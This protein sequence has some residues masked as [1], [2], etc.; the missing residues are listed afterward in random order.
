MTQKQKMID[1][2]TRCIATRSPVKI[3]GIKDKCGD[4]VAR[5]RVSSIISAIKE[6]GIFNGCDFYTYSEADVQIERSVPSRKQYF[7]LYLALRNPADK[8]HVIDSVRTLMQKAFENGSAVNVASLA[9]GESKTRA[10]VSYVSKKYFEGARFSVSRQSNSL[11]VI[12]NKPVQQA[13]DKVL[14]LIDAAI[15]SESR[16]VAVPENMS[17]DL[18]RKN[19]S[20]IKTIPEYS[21][22]ELSTQRRVGGFYLMVGN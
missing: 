9:I 18:L 13:Q 6:E 5:N 11:H 1:L 4:D 16:C 15:N 12:Y 3:T 10:Y 2:M 20:I 8:E 19:L 21:K 7:D 14:Q 22:Y 17:I